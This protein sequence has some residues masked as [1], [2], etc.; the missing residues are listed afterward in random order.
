MNSVLGNN[1]ANPLPIEIGMRNIVENKE[2]ASSFIDHVKNT[3]VGSFNTLKTSLVAVNRL[4][5]SLLSNIL[6]S[7]DFLL[8]GIIVISSSLFIYMY[9]IHGTN[10][11]GEMNRRWDSLNMSFFKDQVSDSSS[12]GSSGS[13]GSTSSSTTESLISS[14]PELPGVT[15]LKE[16]SDHSKKQWDLYKGDEDL[17]TQVENGYLNFD[18]IHPL[19]QYEYLNPINSQLVLYYTYFNTKIKE[20]TNQFVLK[21]VELDNNFP[22]AQLK[23]ILTDYNR[24]MADISE[25]SDFIPLFNEA[26]QLLT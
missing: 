14:T 23:A 18:D 21:L 19:F 22:E 25:F 13:T 2:L 11:L 17:C 4:N 20:I 3:D 9:K 6:N 10:F 24:P 12:E 1:P 7:N 15:E 8:G 16:L 5:E 26:L